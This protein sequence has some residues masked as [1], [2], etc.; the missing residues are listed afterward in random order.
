MRPLAA[1][2]L[3]SGAA[4]PSVTV[5]GSPAD[6]GTPIGKVVVGV[7]SLPTSSNSRTVK[8]PLRCLNGMRTSTDCN[9]P[10]AFGTTP[11]NGITWP[12]VPSVKSTSYSDARPDAPSSPDAVQPIF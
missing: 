6:K 9:D 3:V 12:L 5:Y 4:A 7:P 11:F 8:V 10:E 1:P 2:P